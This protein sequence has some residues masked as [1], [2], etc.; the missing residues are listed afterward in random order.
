M[1]QEKRPMRDRAN[2]M[3]PLFVQLYGTPGM[4]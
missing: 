4:E 1:K 3:H 2:K